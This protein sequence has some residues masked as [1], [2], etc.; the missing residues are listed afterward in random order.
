MYEVVGIS[1]EELFD[2]PGYRNILLH[3]VNVSIITYN[4]GEY[5][6]AWMKFNMLFLQFDAKVRD[7]VMCFVLFD[8]FCPFNVPLHLLRGIL[9][10][11]LPEG[12][13]SL[14]KLGWSVLYC[15]TN[16]K[17]SLNLQ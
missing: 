16:L 1:L 5:I 12:S 9:P 7:T 14:Q 2:F 3:V 6:D 13:E 15:K 8:G 11:Q 4:G 17:L 10:P